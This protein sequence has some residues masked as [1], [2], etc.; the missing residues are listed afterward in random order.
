MRRYGSG[1]VQE[2]RAPAKYFKE[3]TNYGGVGGAIS[4]GRGKSEE[5]WSKV[6][7]SLRWRDRGRSL[8][9]YWSLGIQASWW[10]L[11]TLRKGYRGWGGG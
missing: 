8:R 5:P 1:S 4:P 6:V 11:G 3:G 10:D 2:N 7:P 9:G